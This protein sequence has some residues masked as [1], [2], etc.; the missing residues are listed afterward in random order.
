MIYIDE[1]GIDIEDEKTHGWSKKGE[2]IIAEKIGN[3]SKRKRISFIGA[4]NYEKRQLF[5]PFYSENYT[6]TD[7]FLT[8]VK[9]VLVPEL[10]PHMVVIMDNAS[11]HKSQKIRDL[12]ESTGAELLYLPKYSPD[13]NPIEKYWRPLKIQIQK[14]M[15]FCKNFDEIMTHIFCKN[16]CQEIYN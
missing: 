8:L 14:A 2:K 10:K 9:M 13:L 5:A 12:I 4:L 11:F 7:V 16:K 15:Q 3:R 6:N 1:C